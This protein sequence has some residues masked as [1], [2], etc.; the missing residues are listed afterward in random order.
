MLYD[1]RDATI[2]IIIRRMCTRSIE[3][4][5]QL[6]VASQRSIAG[7]RAHKDEGE[8]VKGRGNTELT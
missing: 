6:R 2:H 3:K 5:Y 4:I 1:Q 7:P 8:R